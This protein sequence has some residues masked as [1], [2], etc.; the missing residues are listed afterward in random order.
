M[1]FVVRFTSSLE[2]SLFFNHAERR[3]ATAFEEEGMKNFQDP[4]G[5]IEAFLQYVHSCCKT[6][7]LD[8]HYYL[9][10]YSTLVQS[11]GIGKTLLVKQTLEVEFGV[12]VCLRPDSSNG[13]PPRTHRVADFLLAALEGPANLG[14]FQNNIIDEFN[15]WSSDNEVDFHLCTH[16]ISRKKALIAQ[17]NEHL[18][19]TA[20]LEKLAKSRVQTEGLAQVPNLPSELDLFLFIYDEA[21]YFLPKEADLTQPNDSQ[22]PAIESS[23]HKIF[24]SYRKHWKSGFLPKNA[25]AILLATQSRV[26]NFAPAKSQDSSQRK[27]G[28]ATNLFH[29]FYLVSTMDVVDRSKLKAAVCS[30]EIKTLACLLTL[31]R[32]L[33]YAS[34]EIDMLSR[35]GEEDWVFQMWKLVEFAEEKLLCGSPS[36]L[37]LACCRVPLNVSPLSRLAHALVA[38]HMAICMF[39]SEDRSSLM[40]RYASEP[41]LA[42]ASAKMTRNDLNRAAMV[43]AIHKSITRGEVNVGFVG[44]LAAQLLLL[45]ARDSLV[46]PDLCSEIQVHSMTSSMGTLKIVESMPSSGRQP[47]MASSKAATTASDDTEAS[48]ENFRSM[49]QTAYENDGVVTQMGNTL[50]SVSSL[51]GST[52]MQTVESSG[53]VEPNAKDVAPLPASLG[54]AVHEPSSK[55]KLGKD[56]FVSTEC[57][58]RTFL[59][60]FC[61]TPESFVDDLFGNSTALVRFTHFVPIVFTPSKQ[62]HLKTAYDRASGMVCKPGQRGVDLIIP[63]KVLSPTETEGDVGYSCLLIQVKNVKTVSHSLQAD[64]LAK[65]ALAYSFPDLSHDQFVSRYYMVLYMNVGDSIVQKS[66]KFPQAVAPRTRSRQALAPYPRGFHMA[67]LDVSVFPFLARMQETFKALKT[68]LDKGA[69]PV[70]QCASEPEKQRARAMLP[71][72]YEA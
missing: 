7:W 71:V 58:L 62:E 20:V 65:A 55:L 60:T 11:S 1:T 15:F 28:K 21:S 25:F 34:F 16:D 29:P 35:A 36:Q 23:S 40:V 56:D 10:A 41:V 51:P 64:Y 18:N 5:N 3:T 43:N 70:N 57:L 47:E 17:W 50:V 63:I 12:Y 4:L 59:K 54:Q 27:G 37:P 48:Q 32:P 2:D 6:Y 46:L 38:E 31:G 13:Y 42:E 39:V 61:G 30:K 69:D 26:S 53:L 49:G 68:L 72:T 33:W 8:E 14:H 67:G 45:F 24:R 22:D 9:A 19:N 66:D 44:E 52:S